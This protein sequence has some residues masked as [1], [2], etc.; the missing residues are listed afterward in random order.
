MRKE[1][2]STVGSRLVLFVI[3]FSLF[4][5]NIILIIVC[6]EV[7]DERLS[8]VLLILVMSPWATIFLLSLIILFHFSLRVFVFREDPEESYP[9]FILTIYYYLTLFSLKISEKILKK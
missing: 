8:L 7:P 6:R 5:C 3:G 4:V 9:N 2:E 1:L